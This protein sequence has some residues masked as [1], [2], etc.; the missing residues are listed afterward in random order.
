M[1]SNETLFERR[2]E[3][4]EEVVMKAKFVVPISRHSDEAANNANGMMIESRHHC[5]RLIITMD[6]SDDPDCRPTSKDMDG[7]QAMVIDIKPKKAVE[8]M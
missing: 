1:C 7:R 2:C 6:N 4:E 8:R 5:I 3:R